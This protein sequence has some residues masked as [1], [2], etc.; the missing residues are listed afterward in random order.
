MTQDYKVIQG[1][2]EATLSR[3]GLTT[4][5]LDWPNTEDLE[6]RYRVMLSGL[7]RV[8]GTLSLLDVGCGLAFLADHLDSRPDLPPIAYRGI[9]LSPA[10]TEAAHQRRPDLDLETRD[11]I[12][13]PLSAG[14]CDFAILNGVFTVKASLDH[15]AMKGFALALLKAVWPSCRKGL[16]F[17]VMS[18]H[19]DWMRDD[20]FHWPMDDAVASL[21]TE[22]SRHIRIRADYGLYE[23]TLFIYRESNVD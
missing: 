15:A 21:R 13:A 19:V 14:A 9:D 5:G 7:P 4:K 23:Y 8:D 11:L 2:Y 17:N 16:A 12:A 10:M 1:H 18:I 3:H 6:T 22:L 20:L